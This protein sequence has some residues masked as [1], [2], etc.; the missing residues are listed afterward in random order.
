MNSNI[1]DDGDGENNR[2]GGLNHATYALKKQHIFI[3]QTEL[4]TKKPAGLTEMVM[5]VVM[6][7]V[8]VVMT[9][10]EVNKRYKVLEINN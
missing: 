6:M 2:G 3:S 5:I 9:H 4:E 7:M 10:R 1:H 8:T